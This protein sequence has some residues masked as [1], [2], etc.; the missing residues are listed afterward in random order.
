MID[1]SSYPIL[2]SNISALKD[3]S[4]DNRDDVTEVY[5]TESD[6]PAVNFDK[7]KEEYVKSL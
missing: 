2:S 3:T 7:V 1:I 6:R 5:M 4:M